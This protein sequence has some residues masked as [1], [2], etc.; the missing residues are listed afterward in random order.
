MCARTHTDTKTGMQSHLSADR[1]IFL[2]GKNPEQCTG[3][4][5]NRSQEE[6]DLFKMKCKTPDHQVVLLVTFT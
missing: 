2:R 3:R 4:L 1:N 5:L 6:K